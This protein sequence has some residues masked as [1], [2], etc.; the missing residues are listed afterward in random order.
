MLFCQNVFRAIDGVSAGP[1][2]QRNNSFSP[3]QR[4]GHL[5]GMLWFSCFFLSSAL[6]QCRAQAA[7]HFEPCSLVA[8]HCCWIYSG[9]SRCLK[10]A[11]S[12]L[13]HLFCCYFREF[14]MWHVAF[15]KKWLMHSFVVNRQG[16]W[17]P[18]YCFG[19]L[20]LKNVIERPELWNLFRSWTQNAWVAWLSIIWLKPIAWQ[21]V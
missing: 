20:S 2:V 7:P 1:W 9:M 21:V 16:D 13:E 6:H 12:F 18:S 3:I 17:I 11:L 5:L 15:R 8:K 14:A 10:F 19:W 4:V